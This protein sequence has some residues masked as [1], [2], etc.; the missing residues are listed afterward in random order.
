M[1]CDKRGDPF[2][3]VAA[4]VFSKLSSFMSRHFTTLNQRIGAVCVK[5]LNLVEENQQTNKHVV[6]VQLLSDT[7]LLQGVGQ[8]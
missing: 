5:V 8:K 7:V 3:S 1:P 4:V 6:S 2:P